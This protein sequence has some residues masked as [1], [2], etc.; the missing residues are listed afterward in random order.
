M[1]AGRFTEGSPAAEK[2]READEKLREVEI[3]QPY[4]IGKYEVTVGQFTRFTGATGYRT[5]AEKGTS[6]GSGWDGKALVQRR[7][8]T[9][10]SPGFAQTPDHPVTIV[11]YD[12]A[13]AFTDWLSRVAGR[14]VSLPTEAQWEH[15]YRAGTKG[16]YF[17]GATEKDALALGWFKDN[18]LGGTHPVGQKKPNAWGLFDMGG[19]VAEW[20]ADWYAPYP[21][22]PG[23]DP[24]ATQ[25]DASDK[26]RRV[27]RGGSWLREAKHGRAAARYRN[28]PGSRNADNGFRVVASVD[29]S[30]QAAATA[31]N[32]TPAPPPAPVPPA[33]KPNKPQQQASGGCDQQTAIGLGCTGTLGAVILVAF[34]LL[35]RRGGGDRVS[36][37]KGEDG[38]WIDAPKHLAGTTLHFRR[39]GR[40]GTHDGHVVLEASD[41]GQF[42]YTGATPLVVEMV[43]LIRPQAQA[44]P[45]AGQGTAASRVVH[46]HHHHHHHHDTHRDDDD[47]FR[48]FPSAY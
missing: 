45:R 7:E 11:T 28:T 25:P 18:A 16:A 9:W 39:R 48:G 42:V 22:G 32:N 14:K 40:T 30:P 19:N 36:F 12:D 5:E 4:Y 6:G 38:F 37:R 2:G 23:K 8:F 15:A 17:D 33:A 24:L 13:L 20:C 35:F 3:S 41:V 34:A 29:A 46:H 44:R 43:R 26:A 27:L 21:D 31:P 47:R 1:P 10:K